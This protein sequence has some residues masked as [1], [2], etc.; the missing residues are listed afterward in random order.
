M[1]I[2]FKDICLDDEEIILEDWEIESIE[3]D[4]VGKFI[5]TNDDGFYFV[6]D[7]YEEV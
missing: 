4:A 3:K 2:K 6:C 5:I 7:D 1:G